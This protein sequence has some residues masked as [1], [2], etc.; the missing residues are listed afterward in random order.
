MHNIE[1]PNGEVIELDYDD[2]KHRY[3]VGD[4]V[5]PSVTRVV[6]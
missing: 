2:V 4:D 1:F 6:D 5:V 3:M